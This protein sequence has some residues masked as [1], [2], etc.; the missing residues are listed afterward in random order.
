MRISTACAGPSPHSTRVGSPPSRT[1]G[2]SHEPSTSAGA[3]SRPATC[4]FGSGSRYR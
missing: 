1:P 3:S 4:R 2:R